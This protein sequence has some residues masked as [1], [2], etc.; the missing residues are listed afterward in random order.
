MRTF[1]IIAF[2]AA[3]AATPVQ[4]GI[5]GREQKAAPEFVHTLNGSGL[6]VGRT[7]VAIAENFQNEDKTIDIPKVLRPYMGGEEKIAIG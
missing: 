5:F 6:A 2:A 7:M 1:T 4:A 3:V